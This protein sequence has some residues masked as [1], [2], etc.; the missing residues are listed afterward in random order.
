MKRGSL[1]RYDGRKV[2]GYDGRGEGG[3]VGRGNGIRSVACSI[4]NVIKSAR[5][6]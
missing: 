5:F 6:V 1:G 4:I 3:T 2:R